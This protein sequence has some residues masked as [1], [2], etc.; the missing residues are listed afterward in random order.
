MLVQGREQKKRNIPGPERH[1]TSFEPDNLPYLL[2]RVVACR[3]DK[4]EAIYMLVQEKKNKK[5]N[6]TGPERRVTSF[7]PDNLPYLPRRVVACRSDKYE[8]IYIC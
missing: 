7:E 4:Y 2:R 1:V 6:K 8:A 5:E 3:S